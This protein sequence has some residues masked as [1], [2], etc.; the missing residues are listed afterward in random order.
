MVWTDTRH[1]TFDAIGMQVVETLTLDATKDVLVGV[2]VAAAAAAVVFLVKAAMSAVVVQ[3][4]V[5]EDLPGAAMAPTR[6]N[7]DGLDGCVSSVCIDTGTRETMYGARDIL[8]RL[9]IA[10][11]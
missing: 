7:L 3:E 6:Q 5:A 4:E 1:S 9:G 11:T 2:V 8:K 10:Q